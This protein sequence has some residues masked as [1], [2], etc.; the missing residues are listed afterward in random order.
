MRSL[1]PTAV[2]F[3]VL[4]ILI[5]TYVP[6]SVSSLPIAIFQNRNSLPANSSH[7]DDKLVFDVAFALVL[8]VALAM[9]YL[10]IASRMTIDRFFILINRLGLSENFIFL[11]E[12]SITFA[13]EVVDQILYLRI[14]NILGIVLSLFIDANANDAGRDFT[15]PM[16]G[17]ANPISTTARFV[18]HR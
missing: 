1:Y 7:T 3:G 14:G 9:T 6:M 4:L 8:F 12:V 10:L 2:P 13:E 18:P 16:G 5:L 11:A 15:R 17:L